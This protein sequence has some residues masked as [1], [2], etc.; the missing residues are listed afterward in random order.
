MQQHPGS[1]LPPPPGQGYPSTQG[2]GIPYGRPARPGSV[3]AAGVLLIVAGSLAALFGLLFLVAGLAV[4]G[5]S[6]GPFS[7][8]G[9]AV[10]V[11][12]AV[13][14]V[15]AVFEIVAGA[16]VL[17]LHNGWRIVGIVFASLGVLFSALSVLGS[18]S[19]ED[20]TTFDGNT[21]VTHSG[22]RPGGIV[23][24]LIFVGVYLFVL[25]ALARNARWFQGS[26]P[27]GQWPPPQ[28]QPAPGQ[29][30]V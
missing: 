15:Y 27:P 12:G 5:R 22:P 8:V 11:V 3:T 13:V 23:F 25:V 16:K 19:S 24:G 17:A 1:G 21:F 28:Q 29:F 9:T 4:T 6:F 7:S 14:I 2:P 10:A 20:R 18:I 26:A 30:T